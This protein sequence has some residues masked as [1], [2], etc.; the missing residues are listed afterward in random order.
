MAFLSLFLEGVLWN[1]E[2]VKLGGDDIIILDI[3]LFLA[4]SE[5]KPYQKTL[6]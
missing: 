3:D 2:L 4:T 5:K 1:I 6:L